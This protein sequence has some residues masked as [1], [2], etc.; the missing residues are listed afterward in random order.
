MKSIVAVKLGSRDFLT[1]FPA[2]AG[3]LPSENMHFVIS[4]GCT[5]SSSLLFLA[6]T[7][8]EFPNQ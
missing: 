4:S 5:L 1:A 7:S 8:G 6:G 2:E 3:T